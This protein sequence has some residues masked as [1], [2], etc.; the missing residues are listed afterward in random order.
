MVRG[1]RQLW[2]ERRERHQQRLE[3]EIGRLKEELASL[4]AELVILFGSAG[5]G[6]MRLGSDIDLL[7]VME[8][9]L[10][11]VERTAALYKALQPRLDADILVYTPQEF[12]KMSQTSPLIRRALAEGRKLIG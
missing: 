11:F 1:K 4:G 8:S 2:Q 7:V 12:V 5:R 3:E 9:E 6:E 10:D